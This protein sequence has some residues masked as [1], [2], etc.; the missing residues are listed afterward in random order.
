[1]VERD[2]N[3]SIIVSPPDKF[4][5]DI[6]SLENLAGDSQAL[7]IDKWIEAEV[8]RPFDLARDR[9]FR[10]ILLRRN[11]TA[12]MLLMSMHHIVSD[13]WSLGVLVHELSSLY[14]TFE[15][16]E[17]SPLPE[18]SIQYADYA[19]WQ[20]SWLSDSVVKAQLEFWIDRLAGAP[21]RLELPTDRPRPKIQRHRGRVRSFHL[22][23]D[24]TDDIESLGR[25]SEAT[26]F[27]TLLTAYSILLHRYTGV[28]DLVI[29]SPIANRVRPELE[30]LIGFFVNTLPLRIDLSGNPSVRE[31]L[32]RVR[33]T[34]IEAYSHQDVPF[35]Q[36]VEELRPER[37]LSHAP[38]FQVMF[39]LQNAPAPDLEKTSLEI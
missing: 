20:R 9:L 35:E 8:R 3:P 24:L 29:G 11:K 14:A 15:R 2:G 7:E 25:G 33:R 23:R 39:V 37:N 18:L 31:L 26:S 36:L 13:E 34:A 1:F 19:V 27:M 5:I 17:P 22:D 21:A 10:A 28:I 6:I 4:A 32:A 38:I 16:E 30:S 12:H